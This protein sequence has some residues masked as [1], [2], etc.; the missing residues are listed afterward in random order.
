MKIHDK[1]MKQLIS[2]D[3]DKDDIVYISTENWNIMFDGNRSLKRYPNDDYIK[4]L[5]TFYVNKILGKVTDV[6]EN[7]TID[8]KNVKFRLTFKNSIKI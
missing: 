5:K 2:E 3:F 4:K 7:G 8:V 6:Y 1:V